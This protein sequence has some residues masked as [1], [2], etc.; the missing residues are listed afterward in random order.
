VRF[1]SRTRRESAVAATF[2]RSMNHEH[3]YRR[4]IT[5]GQHLVEHIEV[6]R[7]NR[8][9]PHEALGLTRRCRP[10]TPVARQGPK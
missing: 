4:D 5:D 1:R 3:P 2:N 6:Y 7:D 8:I 9:P 10:T